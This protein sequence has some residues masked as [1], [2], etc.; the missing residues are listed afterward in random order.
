MRNFPLVETERLILR[1]VTTSDASDIAEWMSDPVLYKYWAVKPS[2]HELDPIEYFGNEES[3]RKILDEYDDI[4]L[5]IYHKEDKKVIGEV[6]IYGIE[7]DYQGEI[8]YRLSPAYQGQGLCAEAVKAFCEAVFLHTKLGRI[9]AHIDVR[10]IGSEKMI[11]KIGFSYEG[12]SRQQL[13]F[14]TIS[15]WRLYSFLRDDIK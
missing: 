5:M 7:S 9:S 13:C 4:N 10:N 3:L 2:P 15:D 8:C 12:T 6:E 1:Q 14:D 11:K